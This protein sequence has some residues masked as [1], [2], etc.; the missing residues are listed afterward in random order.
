[1]REERSLERYREYPTNN[2]KYILIPIGIGLTI[3]MIIGGVALYLAKGSPTSR[4]NNAVNLFNQGQYKSAAEQFDKLGNYLDSKKRSQE[5]ITMLHYSDA[6]A[7]FQS[8]DFEKA[9]EEFQAAGS[10]QD[11]ELLA[12]ESERAIHYAKA[13]SLGQSGDIEGA[14]K[15]YNL[16]EYKDYKD[17]IAELYVA[18]GDKAL[19]ENLFDK[20]L[21]QYKAAD[22]YKDSSENIQ[23]CYYKMAEDAESKSD[24]DNAVKYFTEA[25]SYNDAPERIKGVYY[26]LGTAALQNKDY[27]KAAV[28]FKLAG[29]YKDSATVA[30]EAFYHK[31]SEALKNNNFSEAC[32]YLKLAD[33]YQ[34]AKALYKESSYGYGIE[35]LKNGSFDT[36]REVFEACGNYKSAKVLL[37]VVDAEQAYAAGYISQAASAYSK[38]SAKTKIP[39]F[40]LSARRSMIIS[41]NSLEKIR[42]YWIATNN[43]IRAQH[44]LGHGSWKDVHAT[45]LWMG[46][47]ANIT[48]TINA[49]GTFNLSG[50][51][52]YGRFRN[53]SS[54]RAKVRTERQTINFNVKNLKTLSKGMKIDKYV[55]LKYSKGSLFVIYKRNKKAGSSTNKF[56]SRVK[57][58]KS[59]A[60]FGY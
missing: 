16:S 11:A 30:K 28:N 23:K 7:A 21:E 26:A 46:Q 52:C 33:D 22:T 17:K 10:Y 38:V 36:A 2:A 39:G 29:D 50:T 32:E 31:G 47:Y 4:Y 58:T 48:Y 9:K 43:Y 19:G 13:A 18:S 40:D 54:N 51:V 12:K 8:G 49:D 56:I 5:A 15:E 27:D 1:M 24:Y 55:T 14:V 42:G 37:K 60:G 53:Y 35:C 57:F 41:Q 45:A 59:T 6:K 44:M 34:N 20:A 25:K 3:L